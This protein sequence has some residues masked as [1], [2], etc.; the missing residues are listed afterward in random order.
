M[1]AAAAAARGRRTLVLEKNRK[2]GVKILM[3]GGTRCNITHDCGPREIAAR[4]GHARKFLEFPVGRFPPR[5]IVQLF[6]RLG[7]ATK[8]ESTGKVFP[9][10]DSAVDVRDA[11]LQRA[12][13]VGAAIQ[14]GE[15]VL[16]VIRTDAGFRIR[17]AT[18]EVSCASLILTSGGQSYPGCGTT[19]DGY[20][21]AAALGHELTPR[22]PA[23]TPL[24]S[25][26]AWV[27][28]LAGITIDDC[29]AVAR[30]G[31]GQ[32]VGEPG[33][34][35]LL[36]THTGLSGPLPMNLSRWFTLTG[37]ERA[38]DLEVDF[39]P[40][41]RTDAWLEIWKK[42]IASRPSSTAGHLPCD[43]L[44]RRLFD[45]LLAVLRIDPALR[46]AELGNK[47]LLAIANQLKSCRIPV[48]DTR[49]YAK[50]EVTAGGIALSGVD[51]RTMASRQCPGLFLAGEILD[52]DGPIG[53]FNFQA[54]FST[55]HL[56]GMHA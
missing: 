33:R 17:T 6:E 10:S 7:V 28:A 18:G 45:S 1:A 50:A 30:T 5:E 25:E 55:G 22:R 2:V 56:A 40:E 54:A 35:S 20:A 51:N 39:S 13:G 47:R 48:H 14:S 42:E 26:A 29:Q 41:I 9:V 16:D 52:V 8:V 38:R 34:S 24:V 53:G 36:F 49:G 31:D 32:Q 46:L 21:W 4:F 37:S 12:A 3:S 27:R 15:P 23:L 19:G 11:L 43:P 44:P